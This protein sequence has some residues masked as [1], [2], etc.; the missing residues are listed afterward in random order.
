MKLK[1]FTASDMAEAFALVKEALG[2]DAVI[3]SHEKTPDGRILLTAAVEDDEELLFDEREELEVRPSRR[4]FNDS[5]I[6]ECLDYHGVLDVV[7]D[8]ILSSVRRISAE[9]GVF[10][11]RKL[12]ELCF[13]DIFSFK[14][15]LDLQM[16]VKLFM[17]VPGSGKS[18]AI[19]KVATRAKLRNISCCIISADNVRAAAGTQLKAFADILETPFFEVAGS[20]GLFD[21]VKSLNG[22]YDLTLIDTPG[23]NPFSEAQVDKVSGLSEAVRADVV[24]TMDAG[25]NTLEAVEIADIFCNIGARLLLPTR[26]DLTRR[27]GALLSVASCC[28]MSFCAAGVSGSIAE[29]LAEVD[30]KSLAK[31]VL[32]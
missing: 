2:A 10:E 15:I 6:R 5:V 31:L 12:L 7:R 9:T 20:R 29:G 1:N 11:D 14:N 13:A 18:T 23:I 17:G 4:I 16:P 8:R 28:E 22:R 19:A 3:I 24:L 26:L 21:A 27:V 32:A 30:G 25:K